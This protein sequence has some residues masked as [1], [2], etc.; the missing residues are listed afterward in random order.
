MIAFD[1][2]TLSVDTL[3]EDITPL[4]KRAMPKM[5]LPFLWPILGLVVRIV[6]WVLVRRYGR[7]IGPVS[8][9]IVNGLGPALRDDVVEWLRGLVKLCNPFVADVP[10]SVREAS[11]IPLAALPTEVF[12]RPSEALTPKIGIRSSTSTSKQVDG[13]SCVTT[14]VSAKIEVLKPEEPP[15]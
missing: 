7:V 5:A 9:A 6:L 10:A 13:D 15:K 12:V 8:E 3:A 1:S 2:R 11:I 4:V 14:N